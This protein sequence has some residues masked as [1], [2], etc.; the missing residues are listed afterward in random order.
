MTRLII[1]LMV[2]LCTFQ[3]SSENSVLAAK[4]KKSTLLDIVQLS[5]DKLVAVGERGHVL[6]SEDKGQKWRQVTT[7]TQAMLTAV[8]FVDQNTGY[9]V[10]HN[11]VIIKTT[12]GGDTWQLMYER[13][14][15]IDYPAFMDVWFR[16]AEWGLAVGAYGLMVETRN[17][18]QDWAEVDNSNLENLEIGGFPHFYSI[19]FDKKSERLY[20]AGELGS[21][22][23]SEDYGDNWEK[24][25]SPYTG[26][27]FNIGVSASG[28]IHAMGLRG[29]LFRSTDQGVT[30]QEIE[31][32]TTASINNMVE[33]EGSQIMYLA[34]DGVM[35]FSKDDG[36][37]VSIIQ[38]NDRAGLMAGAL[39]DLNRLVVVGDKGVKQIDLDGHNLTN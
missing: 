13:P 6:L 15:D 12:D 25:N 11:Q 7:P 28:S 32:N 3:V 38:D 9:A 31:T 10:G 1:S 34:V 36:Q 39:V 19:S 2:V 4:A 23:V 37:T 24:I 26:S 21:V 5:P 14:A 29:H 35:L 18:G 33:V 8:T 27:F 30:W 17:G 20:M 16:N 22:S